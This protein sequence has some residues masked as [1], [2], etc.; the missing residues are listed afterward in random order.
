MRSVAGVA[1]IAP[2]R[3]RASKKIIN[4][5]HTGAARCFWKPKWPWA[6]PRQQRRSYT[7]PTRQRGI[8]CVSLAGA[9]G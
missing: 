5:M 3:G 7:N 8:R 2:A 6:L 4:I 1:L 9:S